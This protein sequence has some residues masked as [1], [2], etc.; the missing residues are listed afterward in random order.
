[1]KQWIV[2]S[3]LFASMAQANGPYGF[4]IADSQGANGS[5]WQSI[6]TIRNVSE[7]TVIKPLRMHLAGGQEYQVSVT[8]PRKGTLSGSIRDILAAWDIFPGDFYGW[9]EDEPAIPSDGITYLV[10]TIFTPDSCAGN[11]AIF[12]LPQ[13]MPLFDYTELQGIVIVAEGLTPCG[14]DAAQPKIPGSATW[15]TNLGFINTSEQSVTVHMWCHDGAQQPAGRDMVLTIPPVDII[16]INNIRAEVNLSIECGV[17]VEPVTC[18][19]F[20]EPR[21]SQIFAYGS[22]VNNANNFPIL[23]QPWFGQGTPR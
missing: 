11:G 15:R 3:F 9:I 16:Q 17:L 1:M 14:A 18:E 21:D 6:I 22:N 12:A 10:V 20:W 5:H 7:D 13:E 2:I 23:I 8:V 19:I 4:L